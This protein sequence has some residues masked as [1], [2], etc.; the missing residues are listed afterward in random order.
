MRFSVKRQHSRISYCTFKICFVIRVENVWHFTDLPSTKVCL[1][2][3][4]A[5]KEL[6][7]H[8]LKLL[9]GFKYVAHVVKLLCQTCV[10]HILVKYCTTCV[11]HTHGN[12]LTVKESGSGQPVWEGIEMEECHQYSD[13]HS[14]GNWL[15]GKKK[16]CQQSVL[17]HT[18][19]CLFEWLRAWSY[20]LWKFQ[21]QECQ[22]LLKTSESAGR[23]RISC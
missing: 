8:W 10:L 21:R 18:W 17:A 13:H 9:Q 6:L 19:E 12:Q 3:R 15:F 23:N 5:K 4:Q 22:T 16:A 7:V 1:H 14:S 20:T 2:W 11:T